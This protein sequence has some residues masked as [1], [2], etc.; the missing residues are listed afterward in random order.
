MAAV[1]T[2]ILPGAQ[3]RQDDAAVLDPDHSHFL[4]VP[5][6]DGARRSRSIAR[7]ATVLA[8]DT[9]SATVLINGGEIAHSDVERAWQLADR[10]LP[11]RG[12]VGPPTIWPPP[13]TRPMSA[14]VALAE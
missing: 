12:R 3:P 8:G 11:S 13:R 9:P 5:G 6:D 10:C 7:V 1:G 4:L 2:V 14:P